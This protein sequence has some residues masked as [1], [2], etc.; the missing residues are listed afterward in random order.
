MSS[1][2]F[3]L[4][5]IYKVASLVA[6]FLKYFHSAIDHHKCIVYVYVLWHV[7]TKLNPINFKLLREQGLF[8]SRTSAGH[9][10]LKMEN[11]LLFSRRLPD[12][13][14]LFSV[15]LPKNK[16]LFYRRHLDNKEL[17]SISLLKNKLLFPEVFHNLTS[18]IILHAFIFNVSSGLGNQIEMIPY[19][20]A[21]Y[22]SL[23]PHTTITD[24]GN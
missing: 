15:S 3:S 5:D 13:K 6:L 2:Y 8:T 4:V 7:A 24:L 21:C 20:F 23:S 18:S 1:F 16:I 14:E 10:N 17:F 9:P 19:R 11:E 12:N 22:A